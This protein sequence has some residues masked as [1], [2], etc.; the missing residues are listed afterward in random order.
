MGDQN[1][2]GFMDE[3]NDAAAGD[4]AVEEG[5]DGAVA[6]KQLPSEQPAVS[7][8]EVNQ[9]VDY[10]KIEGLAGVGGPETSADPDE[11]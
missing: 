7:A 5:V 11:D 6:P 4:G 9:E 10:R 2:A 1:Q 3:T 8:S